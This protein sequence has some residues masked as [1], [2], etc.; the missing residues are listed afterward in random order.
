MWSNAILDDLILEKVVKQ[1]ICTH[2]DDIIVL[3]LMLVVNCI[4]RKFT[5]L[6]T[7]VREIE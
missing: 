3:Y 7:L 4:V 2:H 1:S 5:I 6:A